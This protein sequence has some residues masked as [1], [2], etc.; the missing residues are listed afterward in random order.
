MRAQLWVIWVAAA[1]FG[2]SSDPSSGEPGGAQS[3]TSVP[4]DSSRPKP[5]DLGPNEPGETS[6]TNLDP[7]LDPASP[8]CS[9]A[10]GE[11]YAI[12][13]RQLATADEIPLC[14]AKGRV[15]LIVNGASHCGYTPQ[16]KP[17]QALYTKH[18]DAGLSILAFPSKSFNQEDSDEQ[19]V[20]DFCTKE[21]GITFPLFAIAPVK[22]NGSKSETAQ[23]V[24]QWLAAQPGM[25]APV[26]WNFEKF[27]I[28]RDG[29]V[30]ERFGSNVQPTADGP[31]DE[32]I[33]AAL[34][35]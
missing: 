27:L 33:V 17:L 23:P 11:L 2:C 21:N 6:P 5:P 12:R 9:G 8:A 26:A 7:I 32:A 28:G 24:Y 35:E 13:A 30:R 3:P 34:A 29:K 16:Y 20:S 1:V 22:D 18:R 31:I 19:Q 4:P 15:L 14:R 10:D 25:S